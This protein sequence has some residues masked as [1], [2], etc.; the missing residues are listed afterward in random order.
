MKKAIDHFLV[1]SAF[2]GST[3]TLEISGM[4]LHLNRFGS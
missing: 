3:M 1:G 2:K 4:K